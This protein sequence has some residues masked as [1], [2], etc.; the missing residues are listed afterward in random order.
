M[1]LWNNYDLVVRSR[2]FAYFDILKNSV[3]MFILALLLFFGVR[4]NAIFRHVGLNSRRK[5]IIL[6]VPRFLMIVR[7]NCYHLAIRLL[8]FIKLIQ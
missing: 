3:I 5:P 8:V 2:N 7:L 4:G 1:R 6:L